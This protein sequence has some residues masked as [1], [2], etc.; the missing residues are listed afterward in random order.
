MKRQVLKALATGL[1][2]LSPSIA[3]AAANGYATADVNMRSGPS[4]RYP[5]VVVVP[6]GAPIVINGCLDSVNWCDVTF[7]RGRGWVSGTYIQATYRQNRVYVDRQYYRPLGIPTITF[8]VDTYWR[9]YYSH[10]DFYRER[11]RWRDWDYR[12][13][14]AP[15]PPPPPPRYD[16]RRDDPINDPNRYRDDGRY[17]YEDRY[18]MDNRYRYD[19]RPRQPDSGRYDD[20]YRYDDRRPQPR[21]LEGP[22]PAY[23][24]TQDNPCPLPGQ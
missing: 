7:S 20:R 18:G 16:S 23:R 11:D 12:R 8:D 9:R 22:V 1:L 21:Y 17:R 15:P 14:A 24:C 3:A 6:R 2:L 13:D 19:E 4:T 5:A 10:R